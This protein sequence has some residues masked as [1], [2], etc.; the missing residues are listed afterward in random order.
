VE[1][2]GAATVELRF[3]SPLPQ[4]EQQTSQ[5][6]RAP[7]EKSLLPDK[8]LRAVVTVKQHFMTEFNGAVLEESKIV[9]ITKIVY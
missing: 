7:N 8:M 5:S 1:V 6:V 3:P 9:T 2:A 4:H